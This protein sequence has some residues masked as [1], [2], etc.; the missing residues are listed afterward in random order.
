MLIVTWTLGKYPG[1]GFLEVCYKTLLHR[2]LLQSCT[3]RKHARKHTHTHTHTQKHSQY[4][5]S[6]IADYIR[7]VRSG[8]MML[9]KIVKTRK[10]KKK[11]FFKFNLFFLN[12][13]NMDIKHTQYTSCSLAKNNT[14]KN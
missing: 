7:G 4:S 12:S 1:N 2:D 14:I 10:S 11:F 6:I 13:F 3:A 5:Y 9:W 8:V